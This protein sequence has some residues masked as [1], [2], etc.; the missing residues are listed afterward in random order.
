MKQFKFKNGTVLGTNDPELIT[1]L[2][3]PGHEITDT[4][5]R[6]MRVKDLKRIL[7]ELPDDMLVIMPVIGEDDANHIC[8]FGKIR[9][10]GVLICEGEEDREALCL[11]AAADGQDIAD[12][13]HFSGR[14]VGVEKILFGTSKYNEK[15]RQMRNKLL[16]EY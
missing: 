1:E 7:N 5:G 6:D 3:T 15:A 4:Y 14:D 2:I 16:K 11:N 9:T 10:A 8:G 12:Q 13:V